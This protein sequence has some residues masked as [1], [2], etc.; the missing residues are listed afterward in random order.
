[1]TKVQSL[2]SDLKKAIGKLGQAAL[3]PASEINRDATIKRFEFCFELCWKLMQAILQ[4]NGIEAYGPKGSIREAAKLGLIDNPQTWLEFLKARNLTSHTYE[5]EVAEKVYNK[6]K[7][8]N[9][10]A[11]VFT[12]NAEKFLKT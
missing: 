7:K 11:E 6:V 9:K 5:E 2:F 8:F 12:K 4:E 10:T 3:L 1:M